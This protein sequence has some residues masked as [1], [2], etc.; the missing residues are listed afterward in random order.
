MPTLNY[1]KWACVYRVLS[2]GLSTSVV[3]KCKISKCLSLPFLSPPLCY[4]IN[5]LYLSFSCLT[6]SN[7]NA[8]LMGEKPQSLTMAWWATEAR[9]RLVTFFWVLELT[10]VETDVRIHTAIIRKSILHWELYLPQLKLTFKISWI[11]TKIP[12]AALCQKSPWAGLCKCLPRASTH[13]LCLHLRTPLAFTDD[14]GG[15]PMLCC[16]PTQSETAE[17]KIRTSTSNVLLI[18]I[19]IC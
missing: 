5:A 11:E 8:A 3:L 4:S 16:L 13:F 6:L 15:S 9:E 17:R 10:M 19:L 2:T 12:D 1:Y 18:C 7:L 14:N